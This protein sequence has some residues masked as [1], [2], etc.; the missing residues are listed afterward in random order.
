MAGEFSDFYVLI[1]DAK[2]ALQEGKNDEAVTLI[3]TLQASFSSEVASSSTKQAVDDI[4]NEVLADEVISQEELTI[5]SK[6]LI[7]VENEQNPVDRMAE[8][9]RFEAR[10]LPALDDLEE[11]IQTSDSLE[12][13]KQ[14]FFRFNSIWTRNEAIVRSELSH[15]S[16]IETAISFLRASME[17][18]ALDREGMTRQ[19]EVLKQAVADFIAGE[20]VDKLSSVTT[21]TAGIALLE[22]A[23]DFLVSGQTDEGQAILRE[24]ISSWP[25]FEQEVGTRKVGLYQQVESQLPVIMA[26]A[27]EKV[28]QDQLASLVTDLKGIDTEAGYGVWDSAV[29][30]LREGVEA[31]LIILSL[32]G[33]LKAAHYKKGLIWVYLG[34][35]A[36]LGA[37]LSAALLLAHA[38]PELTAGSHRERLEGIVGIVAVG[39]MLLVGVWLHR[40]STAL[41]WKEYMDR[42]LQLVMTTGSFSTLFALSF[43]AVFREGAETI[44]FYMGIVPKISWQDFVLG[45]FLAL[46]LLVILA[47]VFLKASAKLPVHRLF[48][49]LTWLINLL[50]FKMLGV[51]LHTLQL[52]AVLPSHPI[53]GL[54]SISALGI[55]PTWETILP[56]VLL[57]VFWFIQAWQAWRRQ[58]EG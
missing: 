52:T 12:L 57:V 19:L 26:R 11:T 9:E 30:L 14:E 51:S 23:Y 5:L 41:A 27:D 7:A 36:G 37:S 1:S 35:T 28:Y 15:Y 8:R 54:P 56:Q 32:V 29:I 53:K 58:I 33:V 43:L 31:L 42:Q 10:V 4:L 55:F 40:K 48:L 13:I 3:R 47:F 22:E 6:S 34:A 17:T 20:E 2:T 38:F 50:A 18:E 49:V 16:R 45:I 21:L 39:M 46:F 44:L 24:F 25:S